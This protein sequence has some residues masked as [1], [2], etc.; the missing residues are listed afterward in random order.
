MR[1]SVANK[2][3]AFNEP[4]EGL[5]AYPY[6]DALGLVTTGMGN[7]IDPLA[8]ALYLP[9]K[10]LDGSPASQDDIRAAWTAVK[11]AHPTHQGV[12]SV[13]VPGNNIRLAR[14]DINALIVE[15]LHGNEETLRRYF[16]GWDDFP[17]DAQMAILSMAWAM[18][19]GFPASFVQFTAAA[20]RGDW[21]EAGAQSSFRGVGVAGRIAANKQAFANAA[22]VA[23][24]GGDPETLWY[25]NVAAPGQ[26][27]RAWPY[28]AVSLLLFGAATWWTFFRKGA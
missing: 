11:G 17:A 6:T 19:P 2:F 22:I 20:N 9:W 24:S 10:L 15:K 7:L 5:L 21:T 26:G 25:P 1:L 14:A 12:D 8:Q 3:M 28:I 23:G 18:G 27:K 4:F 13:N 16:P